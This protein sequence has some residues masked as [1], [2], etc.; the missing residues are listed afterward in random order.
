M[1]F[2]RPGLGSKVSTCDGP[3]FI[4]RKM[5]RLAR[6]GKCGGRGASGL[7]ARS[8]AAPRKPA[9]ARTAVRPSA[10]KPPPM[11]QSTSRRDRRAAVASVMAS[12][13]KDQ[14]PSTKDERQKTSPFILRTW[15]LVLSTWSVDEHRFVGGQQH[16]GELLPATEPVVLGDAD[17]HEVEGA[18]P[19]LCRR[20][21]AV[22]QQEGLLD[23]AR[24]V[25]GRRGQP[26]RQRAGALDH[27]L[28]VEHEQ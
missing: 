19:L 10:P 6:A 15:S 25:G 24:G 4:N 22:E 11:R 26:G 2:W 28:I 14:G 9:S 7:A 16:L 21:P 20:R 3:P 13:C 27:E 1:Y 17:G 8:A 12:P 23:P 18:L 5:R